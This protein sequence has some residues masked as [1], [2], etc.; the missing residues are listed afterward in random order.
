MGFDPQQRLMFVLTVEVDQE[1]AGLPEEG[2]RRGGVV[3]ERP[4][5]PRRVDFAAQEQLLGR[6]EAPWRTAPASARAPRIS[7]SASMMID[8]PAPVSPV[9]MLR[10]G[11][12]AASSRSIRA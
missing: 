12:K 2:Q 10:P 11:P 9:M 1:L 7:D 5:L 8:F 3:D 6:I 4:R